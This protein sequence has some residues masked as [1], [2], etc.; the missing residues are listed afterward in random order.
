MSYDKHFQQENVVEVTAAVIGISKERWEAIKEGEENAVKAQE[1]MEKQRFDILPIVSAYGVKDYFKTD[2]WNDYSSISRKQITDEDV[3]DFQTP[4]RDLI[5]GFTSKSRLFFF[6]RQGTEVVGL[7]SI[8]H[9]NSRQVKVYLFNLLSELE[10]HLSRFLSSKITERELLE[11]K[12][13]KVNEGNDNKNSYEESKRNYKKDVERGVEPSFVEYLYLSHFIRIIAKKNLH[14]ALGYSSKSE[15]N[16][17]LGSLNDLR[18]KVAHPN[19]SIVTD[20][21]P[22]ERLWK[23]ITRIE[24]ALS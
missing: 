4:L 1:V 16:S 22:V 21:N 15:F 23:Q 8:V 6:L 11:M 20:A 2:R 24:K 13:G 10:T 3:I 9:L 18:N 19:H 17:E 7:I 5:Y 14:T 12:L